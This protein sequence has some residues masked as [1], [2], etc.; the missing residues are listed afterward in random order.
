M[1][2]K[3]FLAILFLF[4]F[5][6]AFAQTCFVSKAIE[7]S[8]PV[9]Q[10]IYPQARK[11]FFFKDLYSPWKDYKKD[12][13]IDIINKHN[14]CGI[15]LIISL[16]NEEYW[17]IKS[18]IFLCDRAEEKLKKEYN[19]EFI[20]DFE[21][22]VNTHNLVI[23]K[24]WKPYK[25]TSLSISMSFPLFID[26]NTLL[27]IFDCFE[28]NAY[29]DKDGFVV[30]FPAREGGF[31][32]DPYTVVFVFKRV[33]HGES[34]T[35]YIEKLQIYQEISEKCKKVFFD[36]PEEVNAFLEEQEKKQNNIKTIFKEFYH[37]K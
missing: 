10:R 8:F 3:F 34:Y 5:P 19:I 15:N 27:L 22:F 29:I 24:N 23:P 30:Y 6:L 18:Q 31:E 25:Y 13:I 33:Q 26:K 20:K 4:A 9:F 32:T 7:K 11:M 37:E 35:I 28:Q 2:K 12:E 17:N 36:T 16:Q 1:L 21:L 14:F